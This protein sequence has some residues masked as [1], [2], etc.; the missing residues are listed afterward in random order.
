MD[1]RLSGPSF[2]PSVYALVSSFGSS[3]AVTNG[4]VVYFRAVVAAIG[5]TASGQSTVYLV[6]LDDPQSTADI[7]MGG[8][9]SVSDMA[10]KFGAAAAPTGG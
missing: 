7:G 8:E 1:I 6:G 4:E 9:T 2:G 10:K 3:V 5:Q